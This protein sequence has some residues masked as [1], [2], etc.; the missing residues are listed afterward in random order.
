MY[1]KGVIT[2]ID[3]RR[4]AHLVI[5]GVGRAAVRARRAL[6]DVARVVIDSER[7]D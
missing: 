1:L 4:V 2:N 3:A 5:T 7:F 6:V